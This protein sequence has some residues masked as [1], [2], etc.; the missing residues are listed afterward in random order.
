ME[1]KC[2][3]QCLSSFV[4]EMLQERPTQLKQYLDRVVRDSILAHPFFRY[5]PGTDCQGIIYCESQKSHRVTCTFCK[6]SFW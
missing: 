1:S 2:K 4:S 5:C 6:T 3:I